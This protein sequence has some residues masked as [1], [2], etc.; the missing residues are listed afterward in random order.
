MKRW[1]V[2]LRLSSRSVPEKIDFT[3]HIVN[4]MTDNDYFKSPIPSLKS[5]AKL[6]DELQLAYQKSREAGKEQTALKHSK[7]FELDT[8]LNILAGYVAA[9]ANNNSDAGDSII[10]S[11]GMVVKTKA[12][13]QGQAFEVKNAAYSGTVVAISSSEGRASYIW[14]Y[15]LDQENWN[16][17]SISI[18]SKTTIEG[19]IPGKR[20]YFRVAAIKEVQA[21]WQG[22]VD[23][24]VT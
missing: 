8:Q 2:V 14:E 21:P 7:D 18:T 20:Y 12:T 3:R 11:A 10:Y 13:R 24:I 16:T 23:L 1:N 9:I 19:L 15:S 4:S 5:I 22:P 17:G 6:A